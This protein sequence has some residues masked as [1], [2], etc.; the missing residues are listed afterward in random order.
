MQSL[1][2]LRLLLHLLFLT[3]PQQHFLNHAPPSLLSSLSSLPPPPSFPPSS[4]FFPPSLPVS[5]LFSSPNYLSTF[6]LRWLPSVLFHSLHHLFPSETQLPHN[7]LHFLPVF[8]QSVTSSLRLLENQQFF[9]SP[10][11]SATLS[12]DRFFP[13]QICTK[14]GDETLH[15]LCNF[16]FHFLAGLFALLMTFLHS[17]PL[18]VQRTL[19]HLSLEVF[20]CTSLLFQS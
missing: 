8:T 15:P 9:F 7:F 3:P 20:T 13:V 17:M 11:S 19:H 16:M 1:R 10:P 2:T 12:P 4:P 14:L 6:I 18:T 5:V